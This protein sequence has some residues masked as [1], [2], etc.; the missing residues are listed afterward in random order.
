MKAF[1]CKLC[2]SCCY[3]EGG[4]TVQ[5]DELG[6]IAEFLGLSS[7]AFVARFCLEKNG[8]VS[9]KTGEDGFC[10]CYDQ[11]KK[12]LIHPVKP[13]TCRLWPFYPALLNDRNI[14]EA[15]KGACPG[16]NPKASFEVFVRQA[17]TVDPISG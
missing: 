9:V 14:W 13:R 10:I 17:K 16:I 3:G 2:G 15:A 11:E 12:C 1:E 7:E 8:K 4:I 5:N 6:R